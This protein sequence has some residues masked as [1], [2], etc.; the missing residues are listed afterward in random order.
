MLT[1]HLIRHGE[2]EASRDHRFCGMSDC[3][4]SDLGRQQVAALTRHWSDNGD[5]RAVHTSPLSRCRVLAEAIAAHR[6][7]PVHVNEGLR[8]ID[9][10]SWDG[11]REDEV[12]ETEP[13][14][15]EAYDGHPGMIAPHGGETGYQVAAR[16]L[17]VITRIMETHEDGDVLVV[18]HKAVIRIVACALLG[19]DID[20]Y[21]A[22]LAQPVASV[23]SFD[24]RPGGPLLRRLGDLSHLP[25]ELR[26]AGG[27]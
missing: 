12:R 9:H 4:L 15:Y 22:R 3:R 2:T 5:I 17:P 27:V 25:A 6:E 13:A 20:L 7:V 8:E 23:T 21:R 18:S 1:I 24:M 11:R 19:I 14:A 16:A 26:T 10:G